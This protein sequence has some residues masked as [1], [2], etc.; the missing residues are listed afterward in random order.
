MSKPELNLE[1]FN[2]LAALHPPHSNEQPTPREVC[3]MI[4]KRWRH[5][6]LVW[7]VIV[8]GSALVAFFYEPRFLYSSSIEIINDRIEAPDTVAA[9][10][11]EIYV[12][13]IR[14]TY[15]QLHP[16][17]IY[18]FPRIEVRVPRGSALVLME[19]RGKKSLA[20]LHASL[21]QAA[22]ALLESDHAGVVSVKRRALEA[23]EAEARQRI[24][25]QQE[26][27]KFLKASLT[28]V[29]A[30]ERLLEQQRTS[31][32]DALA[33]LERDRAAALERTHDDREASALLIVDQEIIRIKD[34]LLVLDERLSV[35]LRA[36]RSAI[37]KSIGDAER[38]Q[39]AELQVIE[40]I[41]NEI[42]NLWLTRALA[43]AHISHLPVGVTPLAVFGLG[44]IGGLLVGI[45]VAIITGLISRGRERHHRISKSSLLQSHCAEP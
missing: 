33:Q 44:T 15:L 7:A 13:Q 40:D 8:A 45:L 17:Q 31:L 42:A 35:G 5:V 32:S 3:S 38:V 12:P 19:S 36:E 30:T 21:H 37:E 23:K 27:I 1:E 2:R 18:R 29:D 34:R 41:K 26:Q 25:E 24:D 4:V 10:L 14:T 9:K 16:D 28:R 11:S 6:V 39:A 43:V 22:I 20:Q